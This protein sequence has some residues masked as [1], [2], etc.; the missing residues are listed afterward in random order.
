M[1]RTPTY[2]TDY[3]PLHAVPT[4]YL[5]AP[6]EGR[7]VWECE[8]HD[9]DLDLEDDRFLRDVNQGGTQDRLTAS[10]LEA[11]LW[12]LETQNAEAT[13]RTLQVAGSLRYEIL[14]T[15]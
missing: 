6:R 4:T 15:A 7:E 5:R 1:T 10:Q 8:W 9:Y 3:L 11:M 14:S 12:T 13:E 2:V